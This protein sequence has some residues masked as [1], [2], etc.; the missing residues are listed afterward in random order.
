MPK[1]QPD[2]Q[3]YIIISVAVSGIGLF[4]WKITSKC[5]KTMISIIDNQLLDDEE[6]DVKELKK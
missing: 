4:W 1:V 5:Y 3:K 6:E 2:L